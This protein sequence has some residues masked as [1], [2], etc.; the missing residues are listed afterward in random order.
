MAVI[1][2]IIEV[3]SK[4]DVSISWAAV[5][6]TPF[7]IEAISYWERKP[8][9]MKHINNKISQDILELLPLRRSKTSLIRRR[10][11]VIRRRKEIFIGIS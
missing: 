5:M 2:R 9:V 7:S 6:G 3:I 4:N 11:K 10:T 1:M 8:R